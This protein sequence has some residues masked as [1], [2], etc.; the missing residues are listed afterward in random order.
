M[1]LVIRRQ[2]HE[3]VVID[4]PGGSV[5]MTIQAI[6]GMQVTV[7]FDAPDCVEINREEVRLPKVEPSGDSA[8]GHALSRIADLAAE[9]IA[10]PGLRRHSLMLIV[11]LALAALGSGGRPAI[12]RLGAPPPAA[13]NGKDG[14]P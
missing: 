12:R 10:L 6:R 7:H 11:K 14:R 2:L 9:A 13:I 5:V 1:G 8:F 3:A 4:F